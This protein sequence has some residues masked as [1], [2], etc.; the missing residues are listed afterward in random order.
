MQS[1]VTSPIIRVVFV[2]L[3]LA[4]L[5]AIVQGLPMLQDMTIPGIYMSASQLANTIFSFVIIGVLWNFVGEFSP[6][7][8]SMMP[9][10]EGGA[11]TLLKHVA[12]LIS[13]IIAYGALQFIRYFMGSFD[14]LYQLVFLLMAAYPI[15]NGGLMLYR[16]VDKIADIFS[17]QAKTM[18]EITCPH[19]GAKNPPD[20]KFC[21][22]CGKDMVI[23]IA[24]STKKC[25][26]C[27]ADNPLAASFCIKCGSKI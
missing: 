3:F 26:N 6:V 24:P 11:D 20:G 5:S 2:L 13:V 12:L 27:E 16:N 4:V 22:K 10:F 17:T 14:W 21:L 18:M 7:L 9:R 1:K 23:K 25:E 8:R 19:C 15:V